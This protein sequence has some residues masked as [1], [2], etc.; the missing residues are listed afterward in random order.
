M[1]PELLIRPE[2]LVY[3][4]WNYATIVSTYHVLE[5]DDRCEMIDTEV[6]IDLVGQSDMNA[7][8]AVLTSNQ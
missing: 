3:N 1:L 2:Q 6:D 7:V 5:A 4:T 8:I